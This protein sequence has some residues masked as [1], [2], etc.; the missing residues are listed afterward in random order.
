M[1]TDE[2]SKSDLTRRGR[3]W[4]VGGFLAVAAGIVCMAWLLWRPSVDDL[5]RKSRA[6]LDR[7]A[8]DEA[9]RLAH[10]A[11]ARSPHSARALLA[12]GEIE[13]A[14]NRPDG[15]LTYFARVGNAG[16]ATALTAAAAAGDILL[17]LRRLSEAELYFRRIVAFDPEN[18]TAHR[19]LARVLTLSGRREAVSH[20]LEL[21]RHGQFDTHELALLG[22]PEDAFDNP[23]VITIFDPPLPGDRLLALGAA[24]YALHKHE[25]SDAARQFRNL[26]MA[27][28]KDVDVLAGWGA[29]LVEIGLADEFYNWH[30]QLP[31]EAEAHPVIWAN[32]ARWAQKNNER[33]VAIRCYLEALQ[34]DPN[35]W[36]TNYQLA[37]L[38]N[39]RGDRQ[40]SQAFQERSQRLKALLD[41][42]YTL[43]LKPQSFDLMLEAARQC[44]SLGRLWEAWGWNQAVA[45][46]RPDH[47][48]AKREAARIRGLLHA[49]TPQTLVA[50]NPAL[51]LDLSRFP[52]PNWP[53]NARSQ[54][55]EA[56]SI[57]APPRAR[58]AFADLAAQA[59]I[60]FTYYNGDDPDMAGRPMRASTGGGVAILDFDW[61]GWP[62]MHFTQGCDWPPQPGQNRHLDRLFRNRGDGRFEDVTVSAGVGDDEYSQGVTVGDYNADGFPDLYIAN[63]GLNRLFRNNGDGTF[64]DA[65]SG[66]GLVQSFWTTSCVLADLNG[67]ALPDLYDVTYLAGREPLERLCDDDRVKGAHRTCVPGMFPA[68]QDRLLLNQGNG[69]FTDVSRQA[70]ILAPDGK[71]LG[72][73]AADFRNTARLDLFV[74]NDT[75]ANFFFVNTTSYPGATP[76]FIESALISGCAYDSEGRA[77]A[78][79]GVAFDDANGDGLFDMFITAFYRES[80][81][82]YLQQPGEL[83]TDRTGEAGLKE[84]SLEMLGFG[85]QFLDADLDGWPDLVVTNGHIDDFT[86]TGIPY[87][88]PAQFFR[89]RGFGR[90]EELLPAELG[91]FFSRQQLGRGLARV[92]FNRDGRE[93]FVVSHLDTPAALVANTTSGAGHFFSLRLHGVECNRDAVGTIVRVAAGGRTRWKQLTAGDGY[94]ASNQRQLVFGL[95]EQTSIDQ[96][97]VLWPS[98]REQRFSQVAPD[99]E[100]ILVEG[101]PELIR[102]A[103]P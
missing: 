99:A 80:N 8:T 60:D 24:H 71:G 101:R 72:I 64:G 6:A 23:D 81:M 102:R 46:L 84:P 25:T 29:A 82:L 83:F 43:H 41:A 73:V 92:D 14:L 28:P 12:A 67:D 20:Y 69:S 37:L 33:D 5:L 4:R 61:D 48:K 59:G 66:L 40:A 94:H 42:L 30:S 76:V 17:G 88:M 100:Y 9:Q 16:T 50:S 39:A 18:L 44:E 86:D 7:G 32:R 57:A 49:D 65:T 75:K 90:F 47:S 89:N 63:I 15:A 68:E 55:P 27:D 96:L 1:P 11:L 87:R 91:A 10:L 21:V 31:P 3:A 22:N 79:M 2:V 36:H 62:D 98:G 70:G 93:D 78:S 13:L 45:S 51:R 26:A 74:A 53:T 77:Q 34:R 19:R 58:L 85:T 103:A 52:L 38:L 97:I 35:H 54:E 56:P 95:G